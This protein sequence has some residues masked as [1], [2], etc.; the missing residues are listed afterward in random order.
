[1]SVDVGEASNYEGKRR[2]PSS[3]TKAMDTS[4][5]SGSWDRLLTHEATFS[6]VVWFDTGFMSVASTTIKVSVW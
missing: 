1:M 3:K 2:T 5:S 6:G 4:A